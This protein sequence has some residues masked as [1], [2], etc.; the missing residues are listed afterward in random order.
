M[1]KLVYQS[2]EGEK[3][4]LEIP[5][6]DHS[7]MIPPPVI[8]FHRGRSVVDF[9]YVGT[10]VV[11][12][13]VERKLTVT[14]LCEHCGLGVAH[15]DPENPGD[16]QAWTHVFDHEDAGRQCLPHTEGTVAWPRGMA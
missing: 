15:T 10:E 8:P 7:G 3:I 9:V 6:G 12:D 13:E 5:W 4:N 16:Q 1:R 11:E 14:H 2:N